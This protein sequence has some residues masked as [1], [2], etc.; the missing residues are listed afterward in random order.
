MSNSN[1]NSKIKGSKRKRRVILNSNSNSNSNGTTRKKRPAVP[2]TGPSVAPQAAPVTVFGNPGGAFAVPGLSTLQ[3]VTGPSVAPQAVPI[4]VFGK[5]LGTPFAVPVWTTLPPVAQPPRPPG[6]PVT[7]APIIASVAQ[8]PR[9]PGPPSIVPVTPFIN[10]GWVRSGEREGFRLD[11]IE[12]FCRLVHRRLRNTTFPPNFS[13]T[14][15]RVEKAMTYINKFDPFKSPNG[16]SMLRSQV[17]GEKIY[18]VLKLKFEREEG[19]TWNRIAVLY[20]LMIDM[21]SSGPRICINRPQGITL[22]TKN[23]AVVLAHICQEGGPFPFEALLEELLIQRRNK[24]LWCLAY[25]ILKKIGVGIFSESTLNPNNIRNHPSTKKAERYWEGQLSYYVHLY[26]SG[27]LEI[28]FG[29][30]SDEVV[31]RDTVLLVGS[32]NAAFRC[33]RF[34][35]LSKLSVKNKPKLKSLVEK[36]GTRE[37][38]EAFTS[39]FVD[40]A[41]IENITLLSEIFFSKTDERHSTLMQS[42]SQTI[43]DSL[44]ELSQIPDKTELSQI[45]EGHYSNFLFGLSSLT[46]ETRTDT[47]LKII[48]AMNKIKEGTR[49]QLPSILMRLVGTNTR[50]LFA[51]CELAVYAGCDKILAFIRRFKPQLTEMVKSVGIRAADRSHPVSKY[52]FA[53]KGSNSEEEVQKGTKQSRSRRGRSPIRNATLPFQEAG[54]TPG[55]A[56]AARVL[57]NDDKNHKITLFIENILR[58]LEQGTYQPV[59]RNMDLYNFFVNIA[60]M[61]WETR[62]N[63]LEKVPLTMLSQHILPIFVERQEDYDNQALLGHSIQVCQLMF[64]SVDGFVTKKQYNDLRIVIGPYPDTT[65]DA[66]YMPY[67]FHDKHAFIDEVRK[68]GKRIGIDVDSLFY[69]MEQGAGGGG[70][71]GAGLGAGGGGGGGLGSG[72]YEELEFE[73]AGGG[74]GRG[75]ANAGAAEVFNPLRGS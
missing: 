20:D 25:T 65:V 19:A 64:K 38:S 42:L 28:Q 57:G 54:R 70:G 66:K 50:M 74:G 40:S 49:E 41:S 71:L 35:S 11:Q 60:A 26:M 29:D 48:M 68:I 36:L 8:P 32:G 72:M 13:G 15:L 46:K 61:T 16:H 9:P 62:F 7:A 21:P 2:V 51:I 73:N 63:I 5:P 43:L 24:F 6:P 30:I 39:M 10:W 75:A 12:L 44:Y 17:Q 52:L 69:I 18:D 1:N 23:S 53:P 47:M 31:L 45:P 67:E 55:R 33:L 58:I 59:A 34:L 3:P 37:N 14:I 4:T 27:P 22:S 56:R